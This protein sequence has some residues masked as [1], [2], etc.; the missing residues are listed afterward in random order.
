M[1]LS[2]I[3]H[4]ISR[5]GCIQEE[6]K[7]KVSCNRTITLIELEKSKKQIDIPLTLSE[8]L[9]PTEVQIVG[10][11][12]HNSSVC[13]IAN[14]IHTISHSHSG[15][16]KS[17]SLPLT[18]AQCSTVKST[19]TTIGCHCHPRGNPLRTTLICLSP[20]S[21]NPTD[22]LKKQHTKKLTMAAPSSL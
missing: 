16:P 21:H 22:V 14:N 19:T 5:P 13:Y 2:D 7:L 11:C 9:C 18:K 3:S 6:T 12:P 20:K 1:N 4:I 15:A 10:C 8:S 17:S